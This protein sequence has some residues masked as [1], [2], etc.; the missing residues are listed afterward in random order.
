MWLCP[1]KWH[2]VSG[3]KERRR[4]KRKL[5]AKS[6]VCVFFLWLKMRG[7]ISYVEERQ[8]NETPGIPLE[9]IYLEAHSYFCRPLLVRI[10]LLSQLSTKPCWTS[11]HSPLINS[12]LVFLFSHK[13]HVV[14]KSWRE[15]GASVEPN[16]DD[17]TKARRSLL[18][19]SMLM[20]AMESRLV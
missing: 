9:I 11:F 4:K 3:S 16:K 19:A 1:S 17:S 5:V 13:K 8:F 15:S 14:G 6:R 10:H 20:D 7:E 12:L 18:K 2:T